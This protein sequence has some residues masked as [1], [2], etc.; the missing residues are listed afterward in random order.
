MKVKTKSQTT[1]LK[2]LWKVISLTIGLIAIIVSII[3][4]GVNWDEITSYFNNNQ[5]LTG[6][7][8]ASLGVNALSLGN[9]LFG[10]ILKIIQSRIEKNKNDTTKKYIEMVLAL[11]SILSR[12]DISPNNKERMIMDEIKKFNAG[13]KDV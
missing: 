8:L 4:V 3:M 13:E 10:I 11:S 9:I 6:T 7:M 12:T 2:S 5:F 1:K